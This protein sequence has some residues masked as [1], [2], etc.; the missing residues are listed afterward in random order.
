MLKFDVKMKKGKPRMLKLSDDLAHLMSKDGVTGKIA[1]VAISAI[2]SVSNDNNISREQLTAAI[3]T[4]VKEK[5]APLFD[6]DKKLTIQ[7]LG[8]SG[9]N[10]VFTS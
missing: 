7:Y 3:T 9:A 4:A 8:K 6:P 5:K 10:Q 2:V 1:K